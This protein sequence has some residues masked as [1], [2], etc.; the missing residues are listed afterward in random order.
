MTECNASRVESRA[1][2]GRLLTAAFDGGPITS[3]GGLLLLRE[4]ERRC[5]ILERFGECFTDF[6]GPARV[7]HTA[8][9][10]ASQRVL[11]LAL[12]YEDLADHDKL[13]GDPLLT[14]CCGKRERKGEQLAS[15]ATLGRIEN[16]SPGLA[17]E[18]R[19]RR[20]LLDEDAV[21]QLRVDLYQDAHGS[22]PTR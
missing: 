8:T 6:R 22:H 5:R 14:A 17:R 7:R 9:E 12:G 21:D 2:D 16:A 13:R 1:S 18:D 19:Y 4:V 3:D 15:S 20:L 10:L 11:A